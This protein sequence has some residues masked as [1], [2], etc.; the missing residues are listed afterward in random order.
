MSSAAQIAANRKN[1]LHSTGPRTEHGK[2]SSARNAISHGLCTREFVILDSDRDA[3]HEL[4]TGL[5]EDLQPASPLE[6]ELFLHILHAAWTLRRCRRAESLLVDAPIDPAD[7]LAEP[8]NLAALKLIDTY[9]RRAERTF[10]RTIKELRTIQTERL[11]RAQS[12][13]EALHDPILVTHHT[14]KT[15]RSHPNAKPREFDEISL[16]P[17]ALREAQ[18]YINYIMAPIPQLPN[19]RTHKREG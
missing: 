11:Y 1:A 17:G 7:P 6:H 16:S 13:P 18:S 5:H 10:H 8:R 3:F 14:L 4:S 19:K 2:Q 12:K 9:T 15:P